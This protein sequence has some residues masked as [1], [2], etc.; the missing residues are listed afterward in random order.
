MNFQFSNI[1]RIAGWMAFYWLLSAP[2]SFQT[3]ASNGN[4]FVIRHV[5]VFDGHNTLAN[6]DVWVEEGKI[7]SVGKNLKVPSDVKAIDA[8]ANTLL[9]GLIDSHTHAW[10]DALKEA[11]IFGVTTELDMFT[12]VKYMQ[13]TKKEQ[14]EGKD[15]DM[16][17]LRSAGTLATAPGGHG[18]EYGIQIPT[19][20]TPA[21]AQ[22]WVDARI[23][24]GSDY[25][26]IVYDDASA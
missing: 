1:R 11:E 7:K 14:A 8:T 10:G 5:R 6:T 20:S 17:D 13:Q 9:P 21:E 12:D 25:I 2:A 23:A 16:A 22:A 4:T 19:L 18:T 15:L 3:S 26:K 24:E